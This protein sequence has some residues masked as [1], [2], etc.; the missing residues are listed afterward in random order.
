MQF[1]FKNTMTF[2]IILF[3]YGTFLLTKF[4]PLVLFKPNNRSHI[5]SL[6]MHFVCMWMKKPQIWP[7]MQLNLKCIQLVTRKIKH[8][9]VFQLTQLFK[10]IKVEAA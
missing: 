3:Y 1:C 4:V 2:E 9:K 8:P 10:C 6:H 5:F 7:N